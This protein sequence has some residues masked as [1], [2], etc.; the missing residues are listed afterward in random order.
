MR[1]RCF[2]TLNLCKDY[3]EFLDSVN[4]VEILHHFLMSIGNFFIGL[5]SLSVSILFCNLKSHDKV[6]KDS[7]PRTKVGPELPG[8]YLSLPNF[9]LLKNNHK[10]NCLSGRKMFISH[11]WS[12]KVVSLGYSDPKS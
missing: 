7:D 12:P 1:H 4:S 5:I 9:Y 3:F 6:P 11:N 8:Q 2:L 10:W